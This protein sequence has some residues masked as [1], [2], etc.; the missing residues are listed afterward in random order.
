MSLAFTVPGRPVPAVRMTTK[1]MHVNKYA[2]RYLDYKQQVSWVARSHMQ[3]K[4]TDKPVG[5][6]IAFYLHGGRIGDIDNL[7]KGVTDALNKIVYEDD[8]QIKRMGAKIL[9]CE[10]NKQ[11]AEVEVFELEAV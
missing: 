4:P 3:E 6:N 5:V 9:K 7:Y 11:R 2:K 1:S 8:R 10:K